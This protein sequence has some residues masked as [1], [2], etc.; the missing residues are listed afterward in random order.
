[1]DINMFAPNYS[2][3]W[4]WYDGLHYL[5]PDDPVGRLEGS[6]SAQVGKPTHAL[7]DPHGKKATINLGDPDARLIVT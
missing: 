1:M 4:I 3:D 7:P 6:L 2:I 5:V